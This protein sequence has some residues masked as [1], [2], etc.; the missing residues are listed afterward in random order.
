MA[1][2]LGEFSFLTE[3]MPT[4]LPKVG[5]LFLSQPVVIIFPVIFKL[6]GPADY[7]FLYRIKYMKKKP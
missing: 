2:K 7:L 6:R 4:I 5:T 3:L 1:Y